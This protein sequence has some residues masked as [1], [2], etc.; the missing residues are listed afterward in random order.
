MRGKFTS[1]CMFLAL[2]TLYFSF[3]I[4]S[5]RRKIV[6]IAQNGFDESDWWQEMDLL[7]SF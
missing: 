3:A 2:L 4:K 1:P 7:F 5:I 6:T